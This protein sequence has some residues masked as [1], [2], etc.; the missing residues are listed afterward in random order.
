MLPDIVVAVRAGT[1]GKTVAGQNVGSRIGSGRPYLLLQRDGG[2]RR[3][4][5][6]RIDTAR[7]VFYGFGGRGGAGEKLAYDL[8]MQVRD[9][10]IPPERIV[11]GFR[12]LIGS[13]YISNVEPDTGPSYAPDFRTNDEAYRMSLLFTYYAAPV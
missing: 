8:M 9:V 1:L 12:G 5:D 13:A 4:T 10:W 2:P 3:F 11:H 6:N 7:I